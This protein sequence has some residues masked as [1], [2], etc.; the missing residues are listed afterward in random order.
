MQVRG[1]L[2]ASGITLQLTRKCS[3][4]AFAG[5]WSAGHVHVRPQFES[6]TMNSPEPSVVPSVP[7]KD[8]GLYKLGLPPARPL[9]AHNQASWD[10]IAARLRARGT[11]DYYDLSVAVRGHQHGTRSATGPQSFVS[12]CI[13]RGWLVRA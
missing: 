13:R 6:R 11:A 10:I 4:P 2:C 3:R 12:Y 7:S 9:A 8:A 5:L 1:D